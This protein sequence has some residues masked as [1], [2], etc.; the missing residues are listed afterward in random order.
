MQSIKIYNDKGVERQALPNLCNAL[1]SWK[2]AFISS[3]ELMDTAWEETTDL[4][5]MPGGRDVPY[6]LALKGEGNQ[7]IRKY[8]ENGGAYLGICAGAYYGC[9]NIEFDRG[10]E[11]E[12]IAAREL[13][14]FPGIARGPAYGPGTFRYL[15]EFGAKA[16]LISDHLNHNKLQIYYNGGCYFVETE[17]Y[18]EVQILCNYLEVENQPA[19]V[20]EIKIGQGNVILSGV[21]L[22]IGTTH[23]PTNL[24]KEIVDALSPYEEMRRRFFQQL[25]DR[26]LNKNSPLN[27]QINS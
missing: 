5:I 6:H 3:R 2:V 8:V 12:V 17:D 19:A 9:Q 18:S 7:R 11:L 24:D 13:S 27:R 22:E 26:L 21:H 15:S 1:S 16:A 25:L 10:M 14:F 23:P 4:L 20:I